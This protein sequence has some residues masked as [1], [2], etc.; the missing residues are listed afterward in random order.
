MA[1]IQ[2]LPPFIKALRE[3]KYGKSLQMAFSHTCDLSPTPSIL[4]SYCQNTSWESNARSWTTDSSKPPIV[5]TSH[6]LNVTGYNQ[7][8]EVI[9]E[10]WWQAGNRHEVDIVI[11][12]NGFKTQ[13]L[14]TPMSVYGLE[15]EN[16]R[17]I[18]QQRGGSEA[19]MG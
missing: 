19:Y 4:T 7:W 15:G 13:D 3:L 12:A 6:S 10:L 1:V 11:L 2:D 17:E 5:T 16:L 8:K 9:G 14:L 18:W